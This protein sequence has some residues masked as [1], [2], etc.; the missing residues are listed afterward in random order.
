MPPSDV[1]LRQVSTKLISGQRSEFE[2]LSS[3]SRP[4]AELQI[5]KD[6]KLLQSLTE[7]VEHP[8]GQSILRVTTILSNADHEKNLTCRAVNTKL[9][10]TEQVLEQTLQLDVQCK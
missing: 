7:A 9:Q 4:P 3:G 1:K 10:K 8:N 6:T 5:F 2:C